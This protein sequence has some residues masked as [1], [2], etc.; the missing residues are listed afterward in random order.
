MVLNLGVSVAD[1]YSEVGQAA[2]HREGLGKAADV[3]TNV[4]HQIL[5]VWET[6]R[7][8]LVSGNGLRGA[9]HSCCSNVHLC[10][11]LVFDGL[12][13]KGTPVNRWEL[14]AKCY[15]IWHFYKYHCI[16]ILTRSKEANVA[17]PEHT[18]REL[19]DEQSGITC[20]WFQT[21]LLCTTFL[22]CSITM[23]GVSFRDEKP[24]DRRRTMFNVSRLLLRDDFFSI[25][26][27]EYRCFMAWTHPLDD[28]AEVRSQYLLHLF[29]LR[30]HVG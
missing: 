14:D 12:I 16:F 1:E 29:Q 7:S 13:L 26:A 4:V 19:L 10:I 23:C 20:V 17:I 6:D 24:C 9:W 21:N 11:C 30:I 15:K 22:V 2:L 25:T 3:F 28:G 8:N 18:Q 27:W 5:H